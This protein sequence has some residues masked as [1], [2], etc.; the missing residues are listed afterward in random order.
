MTDTRILCARFN[1]VYFSNQKVFTGFKS[2]I[3]I[4]TDNYAPPVQQ[5]PQYAPQA[6]VYSDPRLIPQANAVSSSYPSYGAPP[7]IPAVPQYTIASAVQM[8][9]CPPQDLK[10]QQLTGQ[11][12]MSVTI[13][14]E[15]VPGSTMHV[16]APNGALISVTVPNG[17]YPGQTIQVAY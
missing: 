1:S 6:A 3:T 17:V 7:P 14:P 11:Q 15:V 13:P 12:Q 4:N 10:T 16:Q 2:L 9:P 5:V 8:A